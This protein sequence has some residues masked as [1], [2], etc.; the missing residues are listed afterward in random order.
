MNLNWNYPRKQGLQVFRNKI[1]IPK[2][3]RFL[4][5]T[6]NDI[7]SCDVILKI[8]WNVTLHNS[9]IITTL[10]YSVVGF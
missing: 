4:K 6:L 5:A 3:L 10:Y 7:I 1:K 8:S 9:S 2:E